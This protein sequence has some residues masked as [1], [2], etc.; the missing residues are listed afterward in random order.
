MV[1]VGVRREGNIF[2]EDSSRAA[3][4][5]SVETKTHVHEG[6]RCRLVLMHFKSTIDQLFL[7]WAHKSFR[8]QTHLLK[9]RGTEWITE[10]CPGQRC[11]T[12]LT[13]DIIGVFFFFKPTALMWLLLCRRTGGQKHL[14]N[15][16]KLWRVMRFVSDF[17]R[18]NPG[19]NNMMVAQ[20]SEI[21]TLHMLWFSQCSNWSIYTN[22]GWFLLKENTFISSRVLV[23]LRYFPLW[24]VWFFS[25]D[26]RLL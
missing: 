8:L 5:A 25:V 20:L 23:Q 24:A 6:R 18:L 3:A 17:H 22:N 1:C 14:Q 16:M 15:N 4:A 2:V 7:L 9:V 10:G 21:W 26:R 19:E 11:L 12:L 13:L